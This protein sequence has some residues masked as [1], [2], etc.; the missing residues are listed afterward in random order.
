M[1]I[2]SYLW[3]TYERTTTYLSETTNAAVQRIQNLSREDLN[4]AVDKVKQTASN[5]LNAALACNPMNII[6]PPP[7][8]EQAPLPEHEEGW[9]AVQKE[10]TD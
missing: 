3:S 6:H 2:T 8:P 1:G 7:P 9:V 5:V 4:G 10:K